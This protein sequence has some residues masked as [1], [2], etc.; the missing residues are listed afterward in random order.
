MN[1]FAHN[2][3]G[4]AKETETG[5]RLL[6]ND[7]IE[8]QQGWNEMRLLDYGEG[9]VGRPKIY[10][11]ETSC[12]RNARVYI[13]SIIKEIASKTKNPQREVRLTLYNQLQYKCGWKYEETS[14]RNM[15]KDGKNGS[16]NPS[17]INSILTQNKVDESIAILND[18]R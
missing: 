11:L 14:I 13:N 6:I 7:Q 16:K 9:R 15:T 8:S 18:M 10:P 17:I 2:V 3:L 5:K 12:G 4:L 1:E